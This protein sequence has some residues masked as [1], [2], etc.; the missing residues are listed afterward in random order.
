VTLTDQ[1][2]LAL[3]E[4]AGLVIA[5]ISGHAM[6]AEI[7]ERWVSLAYGERAQASGVMYR[8]QTAVPFKNKTLLI[9]FRRGDESK[10]ERVIGEEAPG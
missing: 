4:Q 3:S 8:F 7:T 5:M 6:Q 10:A 2:A 1:R 9:P